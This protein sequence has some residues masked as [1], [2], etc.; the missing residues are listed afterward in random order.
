MIVAACVQGLQGL[1]DSLRSENGAVAIQKTGVLIVEEI[2][3]KREDNQK[4]I[5]ELVDFVRQELS[6]AKCKV[7]CLPSSL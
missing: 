3:K 1:V 2:K 6:E 7:C 5:Q 4:K